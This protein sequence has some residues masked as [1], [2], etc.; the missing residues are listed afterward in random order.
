MNVLPYAHPEDYEKPSK[1]DEME[2]E[3]TRWW[4]LARG[5]IS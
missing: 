4:S 5:F 2:S 1:K 3:H